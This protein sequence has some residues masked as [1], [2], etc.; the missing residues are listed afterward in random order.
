MT[1]RGGLLRGCRLSAHPHCGA[2]AV[3]SRREL[4]TLPPRLPGLFHIAPKQTEGTWTLV[5][6][7]GGGSHCNLMQ[8]RLSSILILYICLQAHHDECAFH[9][10]VSLLLRPDC[11]THLCRS[12]KPQTPMSSPNS[13]P[14]SNISGISD[15]P[16][17]PQSPTRISSFNSTLSTGRHLSSLRGTWRDGSVSSS[18]A[19]VRCG[20][21]ARSLGLTMNAHSST[22]SAVAPGGW[23][24]RAGICLRRV[25]K[26]PLKVNFGTWDP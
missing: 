12:P 8:G 15:S 26:G 23:G 9:W 24:S 20:M 11:Q 10:H 13:V 1:L 25:A 18:Q 7:L 6:F 3:V 21:A 19:E 17:N 22:A 16:P 4:R 2:L 14:F 5:Q